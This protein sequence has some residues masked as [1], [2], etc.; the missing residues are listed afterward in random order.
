M[1][2]AVPATTHLFLLAVPLLVLFLSLYHFV[3]RRRREP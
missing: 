3:A 2:G 1:T